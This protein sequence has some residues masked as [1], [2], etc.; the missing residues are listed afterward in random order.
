MTGRKWLR[1]AIALVILPVGIAIALGAGVLIPYFLAGWTARIPILVGSA[2]IAVT[3]IGL[4]SAWAS[5]R[6]WPLRNWKGFMAITTAVF[7]ASFTFA[8]YIAV[9]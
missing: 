7:T 5:A 2:V 4:V 3:A 1:R 9:L 6:V 8:L